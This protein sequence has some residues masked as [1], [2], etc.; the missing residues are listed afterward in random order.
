MILVSGCL[1]GISCRYDARSKPNQEVISLAKGSRVVPVC[2]EQ[3]GGLST[4]RPPAHLVGGDGF[5]VLEGSA[6]VVRLEDGGDV[7]E[8]FVQ[9]A[10][11]CVKL[12]RLFGCSQ[13]I[14]KSKSP[15]CGLQPIVGVT[16]AALILEDIQVMEAG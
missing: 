8:W 3:L 7:T 10:R 2:P 16:A 12:A 11:E 6:R 14:L 13:A 5:D 9:G 15:S 1:L 4:P